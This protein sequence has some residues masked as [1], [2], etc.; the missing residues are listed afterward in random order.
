MT[1]MEQQSQSNKDK[2]EVI[3]LNIYGG[4]VN[5]KEYRNRLGFNLVQYNMHMKKL[6]E[7]ETI[8][9]LQIYT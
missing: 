7:N 1:T 4:M 6:E 9:K 5:M 3:Y 8:K 2:K